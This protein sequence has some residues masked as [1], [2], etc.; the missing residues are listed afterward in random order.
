MYKTIRVDGIFA[1]FAF[2]RQANGFFWLLATSDRILLSAM[3]II[4]E[5]DQ[6]PFHHRNGETPDSFVIVA[7][8]D[9]AFL[10]R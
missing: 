2:L 5:I 7:G 1:G 6:M 10:Y 3:V 4:A 9:W 8:C